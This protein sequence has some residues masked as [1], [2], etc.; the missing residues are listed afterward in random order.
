[1]GRLKSGQ[2]ASGTLE[3]EGIPP[4]GQAELL[5]DTDLPGHGINLEIQGPNGWMPVGS[6]PSVMKL[7]DSKWS[8]RLRVGACP[9][10]CKAGD[11][12]HLNASVRNAGGMSDVLHVPVHVEIQ[13]DPWLACNWPYLAALGAAMVMGFITYGFYSPFRFPRRVGVQLSP[14]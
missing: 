3:I 7:S 1:F 6:S 13:P 14:E 8:M 11:Q 10:A 12:Y 9:A 2:T 5:L 4:D